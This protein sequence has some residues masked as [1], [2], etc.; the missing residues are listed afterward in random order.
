MCYIIDYQFNNKLLL[1]SEYYV[2]YN[3]IF[4]KYASMCVRDKVGRAK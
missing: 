1:L 3:T 4:I 2:R